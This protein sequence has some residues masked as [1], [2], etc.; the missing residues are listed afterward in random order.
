MLKRRITAALLSVCMAFTTVHF[1]VFAQSVEDYNFLS[2]TFNTQAVQNGPDV[3]AEFTVPQTLRIDALTIYHWN[4]GSGSKPGTISIYDGNTEQEVGTFLAYSRNNNTYWDCFPE[5]YLGPGSYYVKDSDW[6]TASYNS[7]APGGM[8]ELR[9]EWVKDVPQGLQNND[10]PTYI[11]PKSSGSELPYTY[12]EWAQNDIQRAYSAG[13][14]P[15][16]LYG[17]DLRRPINRGI[18]AS[19]AVNVYEKM[20]G[21]KLKAGSNPF[22]DSSA[23]DVLKA[24]NADIVAGTSTNTF[25]PNSNLT[26]EQ[27]AAMLTRAYKKTVFDGWSLSNDYELDYNSNSHFADYEDIRPYARDSVGFMASNGVITGMGNNMFVPG[28]TLTKEQAI[29]I[30]VRMTDK[31]D[32]SPREGKKTEKD[33]EQTTTQDV[34]KP[35]GNLKSGDTIQWGTGTIT[36]TEKPVNKTELSGSDLSKY[37]KG[38]AKAIAGYS[39][40]NE[41]GDH[42]LLDHEETVSFDVSGMSQEDRMYCYALSVEP[43]GSSVMMSPD[44]DELERG[45]YTYKTNH[46]SD[47]V[48]M[49]EED[50][51][52]LDQW[53]KKASYKSVMEGANNVTLEKSIQEAIQDKMSEMGLAKGQLAGELARYVVSHHS[54]GTI[55]TA[56][57]DGDS[58]SLKKELAN[59]TG[60]YLLGKLIKT[61]GYKDI[62][63]GEEIPSDMEFIKQ[64]L[65]DNAD[66]ISKG[67]AENDMGTQL[68]EIVKTVEKNIFPQIDKIEKFAKVCG[69]MKK[70]WED[71]TANWFYEKNFK[72]CKDNGEDMSYSDFSNY[73]SSLMRGASIQIDMHDLYDQ[74]QLRYKNEK[75]VQQTE[76]DMKKYFSVCNEDGYDLFNPDNFKKLGEYNTFENRLNRLW[77]IRNTIKEIVTIDG[78][79][80]KGDISSDIGSTNDE[81]FF[82][83][84]AEKWLFY[85]NNPGSGSFFQ[86]LVDKKV[87]TLKQ[88]KKYDENVHPTEPEK[89]DYKDVCP[90]TGNSVCT[91]DPC[92]NPFCSLHNVEI[93][94]TVDDSNLETLDTAN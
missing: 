5:V 46:F 80:S 42:L 56:A 23:E 26:R 47:Q 25:S 14:I 48:L 65:G 94:N 37:N 81:R 52:V 75:K 66:A 89:N 3:Y 59:V 31:L 44:P 36:Y 30:A 69:V 33:T 8:V 76:A 1:T 17:D 63:S 9:G 79:I 58:E 91:C 82:A 72:A 39:Y 41:D 6:A 12:S 24:Y 21:D 62:V 83:E 84:L 77:N 67:I 20:S 64:S 78:K 43:D 28:G 60:E 93:T 57:V 29:A 53:V 19:V 61:E 22:N 18:F 70:L 11:E 32:T 54:I 51:S 49:S 38:S 68:V 71:D 45:R 4:G 92:T 55:L 74:F 16:S 73:A 85:K 50:K 2:S 40:S 34:I 15:S 90:C 88:A 86:Y 13:I 87:L 7:G 27:A 35:G 10:E